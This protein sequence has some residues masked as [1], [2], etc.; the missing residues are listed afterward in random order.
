[1]AYKH[2]T[3]RDVVSRWD[4]LAVYHRATAQA[5][6]SF[7]ETLLEWASFP[8]RALQVDGGSEFKAD[9]ERACQIF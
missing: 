4:V 1:M 8:V 9:F 7:L 2:F 6:T 3:A 5:A